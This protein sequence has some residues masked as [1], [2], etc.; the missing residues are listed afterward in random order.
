MDTDTRAVPAATGGSRTLLTLEK[1]LRL[2][3]L[4]DV[5]HQQW[6]LRELREAT[7]ESKTNVLRITKTLEGLGYLVR[8]PAS[9][10]L[11]LGS[12]IVRLSY[13]TLSHSELVRTA[14][15][16]MRRL[17]QAVK[18]TVD[19]MV[20]V[21]LG[22]LMSLYDVAP[23]FLGPQ[24]STGRI[25]QPGITTAASKIFVAFRPEG[26][27]DEII[28][29]LVRPLTELTITDPRELREQLIMVKQDGVAFDRGEWNLELVGVAAP[30]FGPQG[31]VRASISI[32][33]PFE[34]SG[35]EEVAL[36]ADAVRA[37]AAEISAELGAP[38]ERV[39][40]LRNRRG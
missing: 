15:Q 16:P 1:G 13:V 36:R 29:A 40:F 30:I 20:E 21:E 19:I 17:S 38:L 3:N 7:G 2:L 9:G 28:A 37:T 35:P 4:F 18:E 12:S 31:G 25:T 5:E 6:S 24:P 14:V 22:C 34:L 23:R 8:D 27:W 26:T 33:A 11:R 39:A 32:V 10:K